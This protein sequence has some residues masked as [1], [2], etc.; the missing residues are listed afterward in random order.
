[1]PVHNYL[2]GD[3]AVKI[4]RGVEE[5]LADVRGALDGIERV[6]REHLRAGDRV[7][8]EDPCFTGVAD[9]LAA[10]SLIAVPVAIDDEGLLPEALEA[11]PSVA[12]LI[13]TPRAQNPTGAAIG[14]RRARRLR[15]VLRAR[16]SLLVIEDDHAGPVAGAPYVTLVD[17]G[18]TRWAVVRSV[19][20]SL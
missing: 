4:S 17:A 20:K 2:S 19:S 13:V 3:T 16:P 8:V 6:L 10:L 7:A 5:A 11:M 9:L 15:A 18:R 14:E 1:M 12:A